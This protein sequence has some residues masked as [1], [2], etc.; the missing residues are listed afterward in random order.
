MGVQ[1]WVHQQ[2]QEQEWEEAKVLARATELQQQREQMPQVHEAQVRDS[3]SC[4][5]CVH[6]RW[7][8]W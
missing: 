2:A 7:T 4:V 6:S 5:A 1:V 3:R 8:W